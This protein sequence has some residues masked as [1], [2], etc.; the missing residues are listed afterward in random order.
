[1]LRQILF[2]SALSTFRRRINQETSR[3]YVRR[4]REP[5]IDHRLKLFS[6][7]FIDNDPETLESMESDFMNLN[8][9]HKQF[10]AEQRQ[11]K[12]NVV[13]R[14]VGR[15]YFNEKSFNFLTW[16]EKEQIRMLHKN[17]REEWSPDKLS[18]SFPADPL[19]IT[20][21]LRNYWQPKD[22]KRVQKHDES[23]RANWAKFK[24]GEIEVDPMLANHLKKFAHRNFNEV[25][26][27]KV[28]RKLGIEIPKPQSNEFSSIITSCKKYA[29][30]EEKKPEVL[31]LESNEYQFPEIS[32]DHESD[33]VLLT[34]KAKNTMKWMPLSEYQK[35]SPD[36]VLNQDEQLMMQPEPALD[37]NNIKKHK[38]A[39]LASLEFDNTKVYKSLEIKEEIK[40][41][42]NLWKKGQ[43]YKVDDCFYDDD[44]EFLYRVPGL[45]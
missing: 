25:A 1:M 38:E 9:A 8:Q 45:K 11:Q 21:V 24:A 44:G 30:Q 22:E 12:E 14:I 42:K 27:P 26:K 7:E 13:S 19:T 6:E 20:K 29:E 5:G 3:K 23:V 10:E 32:R 34:G 17:H 40:I 18:E 16:S 36:I 2:N 4:A 37:L 28:N 35:Y 41:P 39:S 15:K 31:K 43:T 33:S